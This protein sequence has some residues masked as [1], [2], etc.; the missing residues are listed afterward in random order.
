MPEYHED[1]LT[2]SMTMQLDHPAA[3]IWPLLCPVREYNW[4]EDWQCDLLHSISGVNEL[5][6]VFRTAFPTEGGPEV[7]LTSR[8][9]PYEY[10]EFVRTNDQRIIHY[11]VQIKESHGSTTLLWTQH[12]TALN[13]DGHIYLEDKP[14]RFATQ[15]KVLE[16]M[17][18]HYLKTGAMLRA[19]RLGLME[20]I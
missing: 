19:Q 20:K 3:I 12:V 14:Q 17:L 4:I 9:E 8:F 16:T 18:D 13:S 2:V 7:W 5:G 11:T 10:L 6:C 1:H 15:M